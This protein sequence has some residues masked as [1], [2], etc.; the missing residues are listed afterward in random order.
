MGEKVGVFCFVC[1]ADWLGW[2]GVFVT[3]DR[4]EQMTHIVIELHVTLR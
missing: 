4:Y 1:F 3:A 2:C